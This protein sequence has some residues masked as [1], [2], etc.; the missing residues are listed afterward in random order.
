MAGDRR[1]RNE[2]EES[3][4]KSL[5]RDGVTAPV[6]IGICCFVD[7]MVFSL[8]D[9]CTSASPIPVEGGTDR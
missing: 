9:R 5:R 8:S 7:S 1:G 2:S 4:V 3:P 6:G